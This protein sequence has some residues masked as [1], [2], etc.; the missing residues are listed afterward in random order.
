MINAGD[1]FLFPRQ[2]MDEESKGVITLVKQWA[3]REIISKRLDYREKYADLF[4]KKRRMLALDIG[5]QKLLIPEDLGGLGWDC[6]SRTPG[7]LSVLSE[8]GRADASIGV[9]F[10]VQYAVL[11]CIMGHEN[12]RSKFAVSYSGQ[13]VRTPTLITPGPG[14]AGQETPLFK[15]RSI[16]AQARSDKEGCLISGSSLRPLFAGTCADVFCT[17]CSDGNGRPCI[18]FIPGDA[19]GLTRGPALKAT[20]L[21]AFENADVSLDNVRIP[22]HALIREDE[23]VEGLFI[24][25]NLFLG[26]VSMGAGINFF[27]ILSDWCNTRVIKG[28]AMLKENPLCASVIADSAEELA[29][30]RLLLFDLAQ[31]IAFQPDWGG[32]SPGRIYTYAMM[33]GSRVQQGIMRAMNRGL[34]LM[35][36]AGYAKE[37][38]V[39]KHWRDVKTIQSLLCGV[40][41]EAPVKLDTAR[42][43]CNCTE[44]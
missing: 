20:G 14:F 43:F 23:A 40:G 11:A 17:V 22:G 27:E 34:E 25:L 10:A 29:L 37:W 28:G 15:G 33:I 9:S 13:E 44:I 3:D 39:E 4:P 18:A 32:D 31:A 21:N 7:T 6:P 38:H 42:F 41:A 8:I 24:L 1:L 26:G 35:G 36:S 12:L 19:K 30:A 5:L 2:W 16:P